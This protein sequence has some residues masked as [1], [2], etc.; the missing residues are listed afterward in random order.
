MSFLGHVA[1]LRETVNLTFRGWGCL[2]CPDPGVVWLEQG[3]KGSGKP[4]Q[5]TGPSR[6][7]HGRV[8]SGCPSSHG[9]AAISVGNAGVE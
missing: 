2:A 5:A 3:G 8:H 9:M 4:T 6:Q 1:G 7:A